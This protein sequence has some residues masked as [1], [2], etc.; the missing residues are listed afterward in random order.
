MHG[1]DRLGF[2]R[3]RRPTWPP[4]GETAH[5]IA[6]PALEY[7]PHHAPGPDD[8]TDG[9]ANGSAAA[10]YRSKTS[11]PNAAAATSA[12]TDSAF[13]WKSVYIRR[14]Y[15]VVRR[16]RPERRAHPRRGLRAGRGHGEARC[17]RVRGL[18]LRLGPLVRPV[19][20]ALR[21]HGAPRGRR[22]RP[23]GGGQV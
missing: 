3:L 17:G 22:G 9:S 5:E 7:E 12:L 2:R 10:G 14:R 19:Q 23:G 21:R 18:R 11:R 6:A 4:S 13:S 1:P 15:K 16:A 20:W 8:A